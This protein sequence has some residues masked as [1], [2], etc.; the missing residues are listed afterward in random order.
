MNDLEILF[1][2]DQAVTVCGT[3]AKVF[4]VKLRDMQAFARLSH[5]LLELFA[6]IS[7]AKLTA[8]C[9]ENT[10]QIEQLLGLQTSL[11][12]KQIDSLTANEAVIWAYQ[13]VRVNFDFFAQALP[14]LI[15]SLPDGP[16]SS[17]D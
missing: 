12:K 15:Q 14:A 16:E 2:Q 17:R 3:S 7:A 5:G 1:P 8:F 6:S 11:T 4:A 9:A 13:V 10:K